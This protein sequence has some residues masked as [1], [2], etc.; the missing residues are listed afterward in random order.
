MKNQ[1]TTRCLLLLA[2]A[3]SSVWTVGCQ[4]TSWLKKDAASSL[5]AA[6]SAGSET[7][8]AAKSYQSAAPLPKSSSQSSTTAKAK[9][10]QSKEASSKFAQQFSKARGFEAEKNY[11]QARSIYEKL[12]VEYPERIDSYHRLAVVADRQRRHREAEA[13]YTEALRLQPMNGAV[14]GDLGYCY[15][16]QGKLT[17]AE[18]AL[19]KAVAIEPADSRH[20]NNLG[21]VYGHQG[22]TELALK[23]FR[24]AGSEADAQ[25]NLAFVLASQDKGDEA[26]QCFH[27]AL[28]AD[29]AH[30]K[31]QVALA[32]FERYE[33]TPEEL[34]DEFTGSADGRWVLYTEAVGED[35]ARAS[36]AG[37]G[38]GRVMQARARQLM[39]SRTR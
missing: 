34:R 19:A 37:S 28:I 1:S 10:K 33:R 29:P 31:S 5:P 39:N 3:G 12:I 6:S 14:L 18:S 36:S 17:K 27:A 35:A 21:L 20:G 38:Q 4:G 15:F 2:I 9:P 26:K 30:E 8:S 7:L 22:K 16:L 13:L 23:N 24:R 32:A 25:Y 11:Q